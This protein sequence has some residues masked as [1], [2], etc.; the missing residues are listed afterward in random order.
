MDGRQKGTHGRRNHLV[1]RGATRTRKTATALHKDLEEFPEEESAFLHRLGV[2]HCLL[3]HVTVEDVNDCLELICGKLI[4]TDERL[5][6]GIVFRWQCRRIL[7]FTLRKPQ[8]ILG[9][10]RRRLLL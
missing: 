6:C 3:V 10:F 1:E 5:R 9:Q 7:T 4:I 2:L 8:G